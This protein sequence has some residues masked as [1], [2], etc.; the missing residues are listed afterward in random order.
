MKKSN[1]LVLGGLF[2]VAM[3]SASAWAHSP[4][5]ETSPRHVEV[6]D[7]I[8]VD[9]DSAGFRLPGLEGH[10]LS[11]AFRGSYS[12]SETVG[13]AI[14]LPLYQAWI[15]DNERPFGLGDVDLSVKARVFEPS[16]SSLISVGLG[17]ELPTGK[18][19]QGLGSGHFEL[20]PF[21]SGMRTSGKMMFHGT[22]G[23]LFSLG[24]HQHEGESAETLNFVAPHASKELQYHLG[25][26]Y[27]ITPRTF[28]NVVLGGY[29]ALGS[30]QNFHGTSGYLSTQWG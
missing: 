24:G 6:E 14:R 19:D 23:T 8:G 9:V 4:V 26:A 29:T 30:E 11:T 15:Q 16:E 21:V 17:S 28:A 5:A 10:F 25:M 27:S 1:L 22:V 12:V 20:G 13:L 7:S 3:S 2:G 18:Q